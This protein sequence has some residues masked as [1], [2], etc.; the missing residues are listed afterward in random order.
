MILTPIEPL[1]AIKRK[2]NIVNSKKT[3]PLVTKAYRSKNL[4]DEAVPY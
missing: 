1:D 4:C 3:I 2:I